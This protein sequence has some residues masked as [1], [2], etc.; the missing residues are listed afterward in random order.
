MNK[1]YGNINNQIKRYD[2]FCCALCQ[3]SVN[4]AHTLEEIKAVVEEIKDETELIWNI[5]NRDGGE[6]AIFV[7]ATL[8]Y[9]QPLAKNLDILGFKCIYGFN[10]RN[11]Y[12]EGI[13]Q[14]YILSW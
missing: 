9:E 5:D 4:N 3:L 12:P 7:I 6:R 10:R 13:N 11:G 2:T 8:P 14:M 1:F